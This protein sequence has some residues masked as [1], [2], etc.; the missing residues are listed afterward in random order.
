MKDHF[1]EIVFLNQP[2]QCTVDGRLLGWHSQWAGNYK[3][4]VRIFCTQRF[5]CHILLGF[6]F[7]EHFRNCLWKKDG[8]DTAVRFGTFQ[9][10]NGGAARI[11]RW[12]TS[13]NIFVFQ[14]VQ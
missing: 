9:N 4:V 3:I 11:Q 8:A 6:I 1:G 12:K 13:D 5:L 7:H 10:L 2:L 14:C